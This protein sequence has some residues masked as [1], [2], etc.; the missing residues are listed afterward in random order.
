MANAERIFGGLLIGAGEGLLEKAR[1]DRREALLTLQHKEAGIREEA[2]FNRNKGLIRSTV[3]G[4]GG[5]QYGVT[6]EGI[7]DLGVTDPTASLKSLGLSVEDKR[8]LDTAIE[9]HTSGKGSLEGEK[10]DWDAVAKRLRRNGR[11]DLAARVASM[12]SSGSS[13]IDVESPEY[14]EAQSQAEEWASDQAG[15]FST[16]KSDFSKYGGNRQEAVQAKTME[17]YGQLRGTTTSKV[18][19]IAGAPP[20]SGSEA[21][22][23][24]AAT[25]DDIDWFT[26]NAPAGSII[27]VDGQLY[28]K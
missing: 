28:R 17:L 4:A 6:G 1:A 2:T 24:K 8:E 20:G 21:D 13:R 22:P 9:V 3:T 15:F 14:R 27:E 18:A 19:S 16:D 5:K 23:Y 25:Q 26:A 7:T 10:T 11:A 12:D